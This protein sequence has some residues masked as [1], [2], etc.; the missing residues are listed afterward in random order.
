MIGDGVN[1]VLA[2]NAA[3]CRTILLANLYESEYL[4]ILEEKLN[5]IKPD[6]LI[7]KLK[8]AIDIIL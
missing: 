1:D 5:G 2:G 6:Y 7:K 4:R 3:G 8:E